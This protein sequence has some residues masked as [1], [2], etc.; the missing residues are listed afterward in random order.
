MRKRESRGNVGFDYRWNDLF[1]VYLEKIL[2]TRF[3]NRELI[4]FEKLKTINL[5]IESME[6]DENSDWVSSKLR[7]EILEISI[8]KRRKTEKF[9]YPRYILSRDI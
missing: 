1:Y 9:R 7:N 4:I 6:R 2:S 3:C 5:V 8:R